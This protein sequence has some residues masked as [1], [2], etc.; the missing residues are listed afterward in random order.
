MVSTYKTKK[1]KYMVYVGW[2]LV[3]FADTYTDATNIILNNK[4]YQCTI[5]SI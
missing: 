5:K 3:Y 2:E 4:E 1:S